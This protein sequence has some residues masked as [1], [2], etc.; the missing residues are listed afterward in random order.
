MPIA[1]ASPRKQERGRH[2]SR[3]FN[4]TAIEAVFVCEQRNK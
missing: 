1:V 4:Q 3:S 2:A